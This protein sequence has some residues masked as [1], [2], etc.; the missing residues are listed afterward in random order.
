MNIVDPIL[1][2]CR[3]QPP[4]AA[5]CAPG[6]GIGLISYRRLENSIHNISQRLH[7]FGLP[8]QSV[9]AV[10][11]P[12]VIFHAAVL[13]A[14]T[15]LGMV[16]MSIPH[17]G[18]D[19]PVKV[20]ALITT[21]KT[22]SPHGSQIFLADRSWI[23]GE[24]RPLDAH[25]VPRTHDDD[26]CRILLKPNASGELDAMAVT[27]RLLADR[28]ACLPAA[29]GNRFSACSRIYVNEH[30]ASS[31]GFLF[32]IYALSRGGMALFPGDSFEQTLRAL[33]EYK[34]QCVLSSP[35]GF[36]NLMQWFDA[37]PSYQ[38]DIEILVSADQV[39]SRSLSERLRSRICSHLVTFYGT[40]E[41][42]MFA[43]ANAQEIAET[44]GAVG[45]VTPNAS[46]E[47]VDAS[48]KVLPPGQAG[49][50]RVRSDVAVKGYLGDPELSQKVFRDGWFYPG[51]I[52]TLDSQDLL[53]LAQ[54]E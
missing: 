37:I 2:R 49:R 14:L 18:I 46:I 51:D 6:T 32:L 38:S 24:G 12:D 44:P 35:M 11:I 16:T 30:P 41:T 43:A 13:L 50:L 9:V 5:I 4:V 34:M 45:F 1:F 52:G 21:D 10:N 23:E 28:A 54:R 26:L 53:A 47:I 17:N 33:E 31:P 48:E 25:L 8:R 20:D 29:L 36:E 22:P 15:R 19:T 39:L 40:D 27:H 3:R 7:A 42:G